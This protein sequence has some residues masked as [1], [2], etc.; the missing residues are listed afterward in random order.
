M[1]Y[2][3]YTLPLI[4][5]ACTTGQVEGTAEVLDVIGTVG[6]TAGN[7]GVPLGGAVGTAVL[8]L[9]MAIKGWFGV[10]KEKNKNN[11][12]YHAVNMV[13]GGID[14]LISEAKSG[15]YNIEELCD[16]L[17]GL[18]INTTKVAHEAMGQYDSIKKD[19]KKLKAKAKKRKP[20]VEKSK[21]P[22]WKRM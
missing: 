14:D 16:E 10:R 22:Y 1:K 7:L 8:G 19:V 17:K 2:L 3:L 13:K 6:Q 11:A 9:S 21:E 4:T 18:V 20:K 5:V 12:Q 15:D